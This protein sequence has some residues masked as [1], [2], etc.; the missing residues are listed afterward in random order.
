MV[1]RFVMGVALLL[2]WFALATPAS[3]QD[4]LVELVTGLLEDQDKDV[5]ALAFEQIRTEAKDAAT[6][7]KFASLLPKYPAE[8]QLGLLSAL[9]DRG[10]AAAAPAVRSLLAGSPDE[11]VRVAAVRALGALGGSDDLKS[12]LPLLAT[13]SEPLREA[14]RDS[15]IRLPPDATAAMLTEWKGAPAATRVALLPILTARRAREAV[16]VLLDSASSDDATVRQAA[17]AALAELAEAEHVPA[18]AALVLKAPAGRDREAIEKAL[19]AVSQR[20]SDPA[21]RAAPLLAVIQQ[22]NE[23]ERA[24][25]LATLGRIGG[26]AALEVVDEAARSSQPELQA[27]GLRAWCNWPDGTVVAR[28]LRVARTAENADQR[29]LAFQALVRIAPLTDQRDDNRRLDTLRT[30]FA[31]CQTDTERNQVLDRAKAIRSIE[32]L[33]FLVPFLQQPPLAQHAC[34]AIVELAHHSSLR[35]AHKEEFHRVLDQ[36]KQISTDA[37]VIDRAGR[38]QTGQTWVR[39]KPSE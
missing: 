38:Y 4:A 33:R 34:L 11:T 1:Y 22:A 19:A 8:T 27:A 23:A 21:E 20:D 29:K 25:L 17:I 28:L 37:T 6:T 16:P 9:A 7:Q 39:P 14:T 12:L 32:T 24:I 5:R 26:P 15:L 18:L 36:V 2:G 10:D 13:G 31:M 30:V 3:G 35:E